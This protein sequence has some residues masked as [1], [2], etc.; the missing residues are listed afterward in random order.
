VSPAKKT[1]KSAP[2]GTAKTAAK[3]PIKKARPKKKKARRAVT[4]PPEVEDESPEVEYTPPAFGE[5]VV[6]EPKDYHVRALEE[7]FVSPDEMDAAGAMSL[8]LYRDE[9]DTR[10]RAEGV[11]EYLSFVLADES[12]AV[13]IFHIKEIIK[14]PMITEVPRTEPVILGVLNLRGM[15]AAVVDLRRRLGLEATEQTR[16]S[17]ILIV[18]LRDELVG[19]LVDEV[20]HVIRLKDEDIE[21]PPG[22]FDRVEAEHIVGVGRQEGEMY[23]LLDLDSVIQIDRYLKAK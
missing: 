3:K 11:Q 22:V 18:Q 16:K 19:L 23:T 6:Q 2:K 14:P 1:K 21:P 12:Y 4:R 5:P 9:M 7:F 10:L 20:R 15:I 13:N 8:D 17:R